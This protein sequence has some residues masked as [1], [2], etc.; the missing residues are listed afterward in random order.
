LAVTGAAG[1]GRARANP[2]S[3]ETQTHTVMRT[4]SR[5]LFGLR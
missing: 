1:G 2:G 3:S 5:T 4:A